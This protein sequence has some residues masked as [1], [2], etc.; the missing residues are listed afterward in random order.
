M[1][2]WDLL[3]LCGRAQCARAEDDAPEVGGQELVFPAETCAGL[4]CLALEQ[5]RDPP[6][7]D[8][9]GEAPHAEHL[10]LGRVLGSGEYATVYEAA[11]GEQR[12]AAKVL[13]VGKV[14]NT[15]RDLD[16][17]FRKEAR[18]LGSL[19]HPSCL[20]L[21]SVQP[22]TL[23]TPVAAGCTLAHCLYKAK[24]ALH[25]PV[26]FARQLASCVQ[27]L[28]QRAVLHRDL[29]PENIMVDLASSAL[30]VID[31]GMAVELSDADTDGPRKTFDGS[32]LYAAPE[33]LLGAPLSLKQEVWALGCV[34][35]EMF[36]SGRPY[37]HVRGLP[38]LQQKLRSGVPPFQ[39]APPRLAPHA[40]QHLQRCFSRTPNR[41]PQSGE[42]AQL[43]AQH[44]ALNA[45]TT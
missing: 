14:A 38:E 21:L 10:Q 36:G 41:R 40:L 9:H 32:P 24:Q 26:L 23:V 42:L 3:A 4:G 35:M 1:P 12:V 44:E 19:S 11:W 17:D 8:L 43:F 2:F 45:G 20:K 6:R 5:R 7:L 33:A 25:D 31:F 13:E 16:A 22:R 37:K 29:K 28:H 27:H 39:Q 30:V 15:G 18:I 34:I